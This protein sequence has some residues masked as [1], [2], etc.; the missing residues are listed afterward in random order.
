MFSTSSLIWQRIGAAALVVAFTT[1]TVPVGPIALLGVTPAFAQGNGQGSGG[2]KGGG[3]GG[4]GSQS[5][6]GNAGQGSGQGGPS[7]DSDGKGPQA[8]GPASS[9]GGKPVWSQEG[10]PEVELGRLSV[11]RSP[12]KVLA[13]ALAEAVSNFDSMTMAELYSQTSEDFAAKVLLDWDTITIIDSPL[14]NLGLLKELW[15]TGA[16]SL[17]GVTPASSTDLAAI[18]IGTA[19]DKTLPISEATVIA[20]ATIIGVKPT[21]AQIAAIAAQAEDVRIAIAEAHG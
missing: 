6:Q 2:S 3:E 19:S 10:I 20:L 12:D 11:I 13:K 15:T 16:T 21:D 1:A 14:E 5:G 4:K 18:F 17:A 9:G 7:S 8:G